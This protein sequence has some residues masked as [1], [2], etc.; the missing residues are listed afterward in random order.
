[1]AITF[2]YHNNNNNDN[3]N[4]NMNDNTERNITTVAI[5]VT[6]FQPWGFLSIHKHTSRLQTSF[7]CTT[8]CNLRSCVII[9]SRSYCPSWHKNALF[10]LGGTIS[11]F[12][13]AAGAAWIFA[14]IQPIISLIYSVAAAIAAIVS[15]DP[16]FFMFFTSLTVLLCRGQ[17]LWCPFSGVV[18]GFSPT[19]STH[20]NISISIYANHR[21]GALGGMLY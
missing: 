9:W 1:M 18:I 3:N 19:R 2:F 20:T 5:V 17:V 6:I 11:S 12:C 8:F 4:N 16:K 21:L 7:Y 14:L 10:A 15:Y 13:L